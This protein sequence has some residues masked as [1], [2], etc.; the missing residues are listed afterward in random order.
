MI[1]KL[2]H[3]I[4]A[5][6]AAAAAP[7]AFAAEPTGDAAGERAAILELMDEAFAAVAS[8]DPDEW[9]PL[10]MAEAREI[11]FRPHPD[12][13]DGALLMRERSTV[14]SFASM[15][16]GESDYLER[17][18]GEPKILIRGPIAVVWG[19]YDF[20]VDKSFSHCGVDTASLAKVDGEWRIAH[21]M[22]TVERTGCASAD[23][24]FPGAA[25]D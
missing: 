15:R 9:R 12:G 7:A 22:W 19:N 3:I 23:D 8:D 4:I 17:W 2:I 1:P 24:P 16:P 13:P 10:I 20:W 11:S 5:I 18:L 21:W 14:D 6:C 25:A